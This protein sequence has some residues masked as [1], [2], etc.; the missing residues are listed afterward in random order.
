MDNHG[1]GGTGPKGDAAQAQQFVL[2]RY[3]D[4]IE[5]YWKSSRRN[6]RAYKVSQGVGC[7]DGLGFED[8][9]S[10]QSKYRRDLMAMPLQCYGQRVI[11]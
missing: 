1:Q 6:K 4:S 10:R 5:F 3:K 11:W 2:Q 7:P 8:H 9:E